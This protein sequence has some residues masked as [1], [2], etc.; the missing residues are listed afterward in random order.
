[1]MH[2]ILQTPRLY[3]RRFTLA[4]APLIVQLNSRPEVLQYLHEPEVKDEAHAAE[5]LTTIILPQYKN[6]LGRWAAHLKD[7]DE[8][9]GWCGLKYQP[10][11]EEID[12]GYRFMPAHWGKGYATEAAKH[13][14]EYG[15]NTLQLKTITGRAH[16]ENTASLKVLEKIGMQYIKDEVVDHCP[17]KTFIAE[18]GSR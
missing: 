2:L 5:I 6:S 4:D 17:V 18:K 11:I 14:L 1:M 13:T 15:F 12:L 8:F 7:T 3:L 9:I 16:I 10:E